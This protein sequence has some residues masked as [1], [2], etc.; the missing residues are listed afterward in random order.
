MADEIMEDALRQRAQEQNQYWASRA[1]P[2]SQEADQQFQNEITGVGTGGMIAA[3]ARQTAAYG[4]YRYAKDQQGLERDPTFNVMDSWQE[5]TKGVPAEYHADLMEAESLTEVQK[6]KE[7]ISEDT[8]DLKMLTGKGYS[9]MAA[10]IGGSIFDVDL[11]LAPLTD[12]AYTSAK[13]ARVVNNARVART[14]S[15]GASGLVAGAV[16]EGANAAVRETTDWTNIPQAALSGMVMGGALGAALPTKRALM[17]SAAQGMDDFHARMRDDPDLGDLPDPYAARQGMSMEEANTRRRERWEAQ[18]SS[19]G[20]MANPDRPPLKEDFV[21]DPSQDVIEMARDYLD[22]SQNR[23][24]ARRFQSDTWLDK[25]EDLTSGLVTDWGRFT[26]SESSVMTWLRQRM[27]ESPSGRGGRQHTAALD[28]EMYMRRMLEGMPDYDMNAMQWMKSQGANLMEMHYKDNFREAFGKEVNLEMNYRRLNGVEMPEQNIHVKQAADALERQG[29]VAFD[30]QKGMEG[31]LPVDGFD[32][33]VYKRGYSPFRHNGVAIMNAMKAGVPKKHIVG[34]FAA[35]YSRA[36]GTPP[37]VSEAMA[38]ALVTRA[39]KKTQ[40]MDVSVHSLLTADGR[41]FLRE[42][43]VNNGIAPGRADKIVE[44]LGGKIEERGKL[45][46]AKERSELDLSVE[47]EGLRLIDFM[48]NNINDVW[49]RYARNASGASALARMGIANRTQRSAIRDAIIQ[50]QHNLGENPVSAQF[51]DDVFS[52]F[53][54]GPVGGGTSPVVSRLKKFTNLS[55]LNMLGMTQMGETGAIIAAVGLENFMAHSPIADR[56]F[57][58]MKKGATDNIL[59][60]I[61]PWTGRIW[62]EEKLIDPSIDFQGDRMQLADQHEFSQHLDRFLAKGSRLQG[63]TSLFFQ[64]RKMQTKVAAASITDK[65][66]RMLRDGVPEN[67]GRRLDDMG[68]TPD[69]RKRLKGYIDNGTIEFQENGY[70]DRLNMDRWE[71]KDAHEF[72]GTLTRFVHQVIQKDLIGESS[73]WMHKDAGALFSHLQQFPLLALQKQAIRNARLQ[74]GVALGTLLWGLST[75]G[76]AY[77]ARQA[78]NGRTD[79]LDPIDIAKGAITM[80]NMTGLV[81]MLFDPLATMVGADDWRIN[82][83]G[84]HAEVGMPALDWVNKAIRIPGAVLSAPNGLNG[85]EVSALKALPFGNAYGTS[86]FFDVLRE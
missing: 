63:Y 82:S 30:I 53:D 69:L 43:L 83:Y 6:I 1:V 34:L 38:S 41:G 29:K 7:R 76:L 37:K 77:A 19:A 60:D 72:A 55:V 12:G 45:G 68:L 16:V 56:F 58:N 35:G 57:K 64:V 10:L 67:A 85:S 21:D 74:D 59:E 86:V 22:R 39:L 11:L 5:I 28:R 36:L 66:M 81:P 26:Q 49:N 80:S 70:I 42:S 20:S 71:P 84:R 31:E 14:I 18:Q 40:E 44:A 52:Y 23:G 78:L 3:G 9:G 47:H 50:E 61:A 27:L 17:N 2:G 54:A 25:A 4:I 62:D 33:I 79:K 51:I 32:S 15:M 13:V 75:A 24:M 48:D 46:H 8:R 65:A 73:V